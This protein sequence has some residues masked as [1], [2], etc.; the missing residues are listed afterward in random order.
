VDTAGNSGSTGDI[1][2]NGWALGRA[3]TRAHDGMLLANPHL[4]WT[5]DGRLYQVQ[6]TIP[7]VLDVSGASLY[8]LPVVAIG[9]TR[10]LAWTM[11]A[12]HAQHASIY[13]LALVPGDPT[14]YL[15]DGA[16]VAM[17]RRAV[18]VALPGGGSVSRTLYTSRYGP[19]LATGWTSTTAFAVR[20]ANADNVRS[21]NEWLAIDRAQN[22]TDLRA[23]V[24]AYQGVPWMY[25]MA[26]DTSGGVYF[27]DPSVVPHI[28]DA[29]AARCVRRANPERP[30]IVDGST[31]ACDW[32]SDPG[33]IEAGI[34]A[35]DQAPTLT[36]DDYV[37]NSNNSPLLANPSA[38]LTGYPGMYDT[39]LQPELRPRLSLTMIAQRIAGTDG[40]GAP[41]FTVPTLQAA[42]L[43]DRVLSAELGR[44]D[45]VA[46]CRA[47]PSLAASDGTA[48][49]IR[50]ACDILARWDGRAGRDSAGAVLWSTFFNVL[51]GFDLSAP[52]W[53]VPYDPTQ[54]VTTPSGIDG[55]NADVQ[56]ALADTVQLLGAQQMALD[57]TPGDTMRWHDIPLQG[58]DEVSGC[59]NIVEAS[60]TSGRGG[61]DVSPEN[62][63]QGSSF[64]MAV[65]MTARGPVARTI[66]TYSESANPAS[67]H[68]SDETGL[69]SRGEWVTERFTQAEIQADPQLRT[70]V[71]HG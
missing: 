64:I 57:S 49:D 33:A 2:S 17:G 68:F 53:R 59:F 69:F 56:R 10:G 46:M 8:G 27:A 35:P 19:V 14:S 51:G 38:P 4:P 15:V 42:M 32:G 9:H 43:G 34:F 31:A 61:I 13:Q 6:L 5:G 11:T 26:T 45:V 12:S 16:P 3:A 36:R 30:D 21:V 44:A 23:A 20:D 41:G 25:T 55:D 71:V 47:H 24:N 58:C 66:M 50:P 65:E 54:P 1:G 63:A 62:R 37:A 18:T 52:W 60:P 39:R 70:T 7:G 29:Q 40:L 48:V 28:T 22:L 67:P